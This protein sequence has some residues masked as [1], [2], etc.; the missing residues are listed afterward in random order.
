MALGHWTSVEEAVPVGAAVGGSR[1]AGG[2]AAPTVPRARPGATT[3][4]QPAPAKAPAPAADRARDER[5]VHFWAP[6]DLPGLTFDPL[7]ARLLHEEPVARVTL[8]HGRGDAWLV[9]RYDDVRFVSVDP[10]FGRRAVMG[11]DITR[12]AP[13]FIPMDGA[14]GVCDPPDHTRMRRVVARAF[15]SRSLSRLRAYAQQVMDGLLDRMEEHGGPLDLVAHLNRPFPLAM[16]GALLGVPEEDRPRMARWTDTILSAARGRE[17]S[18]RAK[19]EMADYFRR[20]PVR[21]GSGAGEDLRGA[22]AD[23][24]G[25]GVLSPDEAVGLA[26]LVQIGGAHAVRNNSA[27]MVYALL[28]HPAHLARLRAEPELVPQAVEELLRYIPHRNA[29]GLARIALEDVEVGGVLIRAG[30][31]VYVSYLTAN[32]DPDVF[33][34][35]DRLD[36]DRVHNPHVSF[37]HG[38]HFCPASTLA[39][40]ESEIM[41]R[42]LWGRFPGLRL[43][44]A[45][46][47]LA[48]ERGALIRG[49]E[50]LPV[51]W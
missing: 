19:A 4:L 31:P 32:R 2:R 38:P 13:H 35:P 49:P 47:E 18:E 30:E 12:L 44:V 16:V 9:T 26:V 28:T 43:A 22:L 42:S 14:V 11:R 39:R 37:G 51:T 6:P 45:E 24:V 46:H 3:A 1:A 10:R 23:A 15:T 36:F 29:V 20:P 50:K 8:P 41:L 21:E 7:L 34:D 40:M 48:W 33:A 25:E 17:A 27:N 5:S